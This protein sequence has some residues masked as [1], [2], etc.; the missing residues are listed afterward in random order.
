M[1]FKQNGY[2]PFMVKEA[3]RKMD[4]FGCLND[5]EFSE[6]IEI[7]TLKK[8]Q[9]GNIL[10]Y[11]GEKPL[12]YYLL[13]EGELKLYK[14]GFKSQEVVLHYFRE[15]SL[16]AEMATLENFDFPATCEIVQDETIVGVIEKEK[17]NLMLEKYS[18]L[19]LHVIKSL[20]KKIKSLEGSINRNLIFD[21]TAK[22][23]SILK[24]HPE[25]LKTQKNTQV[26]NFLNMAPETLSRSLAKLRK[27]E[28]INSTNEVIDA[29][30]LDTFLDF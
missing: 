3:M 7:T 2:N 4:M 24:E 21:A 14:T 11:E 23:C 9:S 17:F 28:I 22:V 25:I 10:F 27:L 13:L 12:F 19:S 1:L 26:A 16:I 8:L 29:K 15:P 5:S 30:K 6:L 18:T 20:T